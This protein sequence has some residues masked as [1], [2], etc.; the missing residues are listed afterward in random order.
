MAKKT[1]ILKNSYQIEPNFPIYFEPNISLGSEAENNHPLLLPK[2]YKW[3][4]NRLRINSSLCQMGETDS[5]SS[6]ISKKIQKSFTYC[7]FGEI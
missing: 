1:Q 3:I 5:M 7:E 6:E 2:I 4:R